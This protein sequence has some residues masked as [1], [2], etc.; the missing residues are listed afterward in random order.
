MAST[1]N[2][3]NDTTIASKLIIAKMPN[4]I[5]WVNAGEVLK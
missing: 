1:V 2:P 4:F 3:F 5:F